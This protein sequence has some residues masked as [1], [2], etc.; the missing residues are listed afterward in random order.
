M[1]DLTSKGAKRLPWFA[2]ETY[3]MCDCVSA[4]E[5]TLATLALAVPVISNNKIRA[6]KQYL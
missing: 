2:D 6:I 4:T 5:T 1:H 3:S